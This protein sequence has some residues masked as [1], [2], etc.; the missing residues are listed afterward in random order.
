MGGTD[1]IRTEKREALANFGLMEGGTDEIRTGEGG[2]DI[3]GLGGK[4]LVLD[5]SLSYTRE[6]LPEG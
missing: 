5:S 6:S 1:K 3:I 2:T 4:L